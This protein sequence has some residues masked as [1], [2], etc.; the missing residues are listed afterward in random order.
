MAFLVIFRLAFSHT[1]S[2]GNEGEITSRKLL[3]LL[4]SLEKQYPGPHAALEGSLTDG[5]R[6]SSP[7]MA[8]PKK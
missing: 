4:E 2:N 6:N 1:N 7:Q 3:D 8:R 5:K